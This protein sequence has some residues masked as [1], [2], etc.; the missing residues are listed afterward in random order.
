[1]SEKTQ[2]IKNQMI[3]KEGDF[4]FYGNIINSVI[5]ITQGH[6]FVKGNV[7]KSKITCNNLWI[8]GSIEE[9]EADV[10]EI[11]FSIQDKTRKKDY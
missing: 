9:L 5:E 10:M 4:I 11:A 2:E 3:R 7:K 8:E 1:M 6:C